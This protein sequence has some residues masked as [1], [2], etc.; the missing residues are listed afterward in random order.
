MLKWVTAILHITLFKHIA[1]KST[2]FVIV[3]LMNT[4]SYVVLI[5][6]NTGDS[7][8]LFRVFI[9]FFCEKWPLF[10]AADFTFRDKG[11]DKIS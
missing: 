8:I 4:L 9:R 5:N 1:L 7:F 10:G 11:M 3:Q 2:G 6:E